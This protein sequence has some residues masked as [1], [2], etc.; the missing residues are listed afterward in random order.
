MQTAI[1][2]KYQK[3]SVVKGSGSLLGRH[4]PKDR[5]SSRFFGLGQVFK[6]A[7]PV[8]I[9]A[10][11]ETKSYWSNQFQ[12]LVPKQI[13]LCTQGPNKIIQHW[14]FAGLIF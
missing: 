4:R 1:F 10:L 9:C 11:V 5:P 8:S 13:M 12:L 2:G 14:N 3:H 7:R 6:T